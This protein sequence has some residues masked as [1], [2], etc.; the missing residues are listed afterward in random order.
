MCGPSYYSC[1]AEGRLTILVSVHLV[2][3]V[4]NLGFGYFLGLLIG[5]YGIILAWGIALSLG[6]I[7]LIVEYLRKLSLSFV[8]LFTKNDYLIMMVSLLIIG[9]SISFYS[10]D[11]S[12]LNDYT[13][14]GF[15]SLLFLLYI[16]IILKND[17]LKAILLKFKS[18]IFINK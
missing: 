11:L 6:S 5:G 13:K 9:S 7:F 10:F 1:L 18:K 8:N 3:A 4:I 14:I 2:M 16:P 17:N 12:A 15:C